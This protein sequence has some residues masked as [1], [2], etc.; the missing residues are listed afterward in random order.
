MIETRRLF[1]EELLKGLA[2]RGHVFIQAKPTK[3]PKTAANP[4]LAVPHSEQ[5]VNPAMLLPLLFINSHTPDSGPDKLPMGI[6]ICSA[7]PAHYVTTQLK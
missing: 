2:R 1:I 7:I 3:E 6:T 5:A 4:V